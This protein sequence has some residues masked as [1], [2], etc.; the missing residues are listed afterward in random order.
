[1][2]W[3]MKPLLF[4]RKCAVDLHLTMTGG[5]GRYFGYRMPRMRRTETVIRDLLDSGK[6]NIHGVIVAKCDRMGGYTEYLNLAV[7]KVVKANKIV[8]SVLD[9]GYRYGPLY[10]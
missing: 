9:S 1:M 2:K 4:K 7:P 3:A 8:V 10:P 5:G 6:K